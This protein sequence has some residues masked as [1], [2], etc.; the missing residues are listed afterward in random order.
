MLSPPF[1]ENEEQRLEVLSDNYSSPVPRE[2]RFDRI[3]RTA[4][5]LLEI[6]LA[7]MALDGKD[8]PALCSVQG[9]PAHH[10]SHA[11]AFCDPTILTDQ[12]LTIPDAAANPLF[13][14]NA[15]VTGPAH[16]RSFIGV[17]LMRTPSERGGVIC[18]MH[19]VPRAFRPAHVLALQDLA[20]LAESELR[21]ESLTA[22][23][24]RV[25]TR[26]GQLEQRGHFDTV[27]GCWSVRR[28]R[29]LLS[30]AVA[31]AHARGS[32]VALCYVRIR[33]F[34]QHAGKDKALADEIRQWVAHELRRRLTDRGALASLGGPD[35]CALLP[36]ANAQ[37]ARQS[38]G[39]FCE[40]EIRTNA[41]ATDL[42]LAFGPAMLH[43]LGDQA[44]ATEIWA[45]ALS[46]LEH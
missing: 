42:S 11:L 19:S 37:A 45:R 6:P 14:H 16:V 3:T 36:A 10:T 35:F 27:T 2:E 23:H 46:N 43:E 1:L 21:L 13:W 26:L 31:D 44:S 22:M 33:D 29:E 41:M 40:P 4:M 20:R 9:L 24:K 30:M 7:F 32:D 15:L 34:K 28:F 39:R 12:A 38:L 17:P 8:G 18:A 5:R 25:V